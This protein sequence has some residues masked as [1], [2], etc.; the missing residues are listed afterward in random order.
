[1]RPIVE[2]LTPAGAGPATAPRALLTLLRE[3]SE[4][5]MPYT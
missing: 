3:A 5:W 2:D 1:M 4:Q